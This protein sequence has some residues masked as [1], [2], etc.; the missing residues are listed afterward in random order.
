MWNKIIADTRSGSFPSTLALAGIFL[1][2]M[3]P[4]FDT[5]ADAMPNTWGGF[6]WSLF[7]S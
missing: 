7:D 5:V 3:A 2:P 1:E 6:S 4:T